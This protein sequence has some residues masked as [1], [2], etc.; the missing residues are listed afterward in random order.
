MTDF[1]A[2]LGRI[3]LS[4]IFVASGFDK[5]M[6]FTQ[7]A[8]L[9]ASK[10]LPY[11]Q[12]LLIA[13]IVFE[14]GGGLMVFLGWRARFGA[15]MLFLFVIPVTVVFHSFW[16][17]APADAINQMQHFMKNLAIMGGALYVMAYGAGNYSVD[18]ARKK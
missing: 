13:S 2:L 9:M 5:I 3:A 11:S 15:L 14:L 18:A 16:S 7:T 17:Y 1:I 4:L 8:G 10:G 6:S 12:I